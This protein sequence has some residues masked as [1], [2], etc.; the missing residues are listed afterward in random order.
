MG[1]KVG[2]RGRVWAKQ[3]KQ[4]RVGATIGDET[5]GYGQQE[6]SGRPREG[7]VATAARSGK[8]AARSA[9]SASRSRFPDGCRRELG[10]GA[11]DCAS[12]HDS[13]AGQG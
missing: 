9:R 3:W 8:H 1:A 7:A 4:G 13:A 6:K 12:S 10:A 5:R 2:K 11:V